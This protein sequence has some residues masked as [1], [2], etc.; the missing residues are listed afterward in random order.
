VKIYLLAIGS[1]LAAGAVVGIGIP[2]SLA[3]VALALA[4]GAGIVAAAVVVTR[5]D[6]F[7]VFGLVAAFYLLAFVVGAIYF[8]YNYRAA[9]D[10]G[11]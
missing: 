1:A 3:L 4:G 10:Q 11:F 2:H 9:E 7:S 8:H 6:P 5:R